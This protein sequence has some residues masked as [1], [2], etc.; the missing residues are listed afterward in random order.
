MSNKTKILI[1]TSFVL[2]SS[3][4]LLVVSGGLYEA[5]IS[6]GDHVGCDGKSL[7]LIAGTL[8]FIL[9]FLVAVY[10][11]TSV[12]K[13]LFIRD[14]KNTQSKQYTTFAEAKKNCRLLCMQCGEDCCP[15]VKK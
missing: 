2:V 10:T 15:M 9:V 1:L 7:F 3:I 8:C 6:I 5:C 14:N 12:F 4:T 11:A 13:E